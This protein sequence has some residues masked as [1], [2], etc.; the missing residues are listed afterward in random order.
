M[1]ALRYLCVYIW[2]VAQYN[3]TPHLPFMAECNIDQYIREVAQESHL[4]REQE[5][6]HHHHHNHNHHSWQ[7]KEEMEE[8]FL[9]PSSSSSSDSSLLT[10][11]S[12]SSSSQLP[13]LSLNHVSFVCQSVRR[14]V[15][16]Y[17]EVL[18]FV[19]IK[20]PSSFDFEGAWYICS[21]IHSFF[22][23]SRILCVYF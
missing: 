15:R 2:R 17:E 22:H 10:F 20:R 13:L 4:H 11:A 5:I 3:A 6:N 16:F 14:S 8:I 1:S 19:L 9:S 12:S 18:G 21:S 7:L 23:S